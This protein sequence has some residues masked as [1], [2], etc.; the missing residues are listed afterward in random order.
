V[1][2]VRSNTEYDTVFVSVTPFEYS[3]EE[4]PAILVSFGSVVIMV[5]VAALVVKSRRQIGR[6]GLPSLVFHKY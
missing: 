2:D 1:E 5:L 3:P 6:E 4:I